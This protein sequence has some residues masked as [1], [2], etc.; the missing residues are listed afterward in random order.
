MTKID[1]V[2]EVI[3]E[4]KDGQAQFHELIGEMGKGQ[5]E[6]RETIAEMGFEVKEIRKDCKLIADHSE[7][8]NGHIS[9]LQTAEIRRAEREKGEKEGST[10]VKWFMGI[11][12]AGMGGVAGLTELLSRL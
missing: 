9:E 11:A 6:M 10:S 12:M 7:R 3:H 5:L 1:D 2:Y 4:L 8:Q